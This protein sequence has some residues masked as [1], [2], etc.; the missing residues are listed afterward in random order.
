MRR[1]ATIVLG[2]VL[3]GA[4]ARAQQAATA[5]PQ[6]AK[7]STPGQTAEAPPPENYTYQAGGRRDPFLNLLGTGSDQR[8]MGRR[9]DGLAGL[10]VGEIAV[11]GVMQSK[12]ALVA[13]ISGP[14]N[15]TYIVHPGD[16]MLDATIKSINPQGLV[17]TQDV[18]DP[19]SVAK[20]REIHK[21]L[22]SLEDGRE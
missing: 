2:I 4:A 13:M 9:P 6:A 5:Q 14:D 1:F 17:L 7:P 20:Q 3:L 18:K 16:R 11:R 12:G 22:R 15:R 10:S 8:P 21:L 19:L